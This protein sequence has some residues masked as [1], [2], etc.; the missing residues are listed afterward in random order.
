M[1]TMPIYVYE[2]I[3]PDGSSGERFEYAQSMCESPLQRHPTSGNAVRKI[4]TAPNIAARY[5][6]GQN[7]ARLDNKNLEAKGFTKYER[8]KLTGKYH[9]VAGKEG[10]PVIDRNAAA[11]L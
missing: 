2:E 4:L 1:G 9:R 3:L 8:D 5:T 7:A 6:A 10:P 11:S